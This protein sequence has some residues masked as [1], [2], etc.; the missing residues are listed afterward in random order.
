VDECKPLGDGSSDEGE[1]EGDSP[2]DGY[3]GRGV[4]SFTHQPNVSAF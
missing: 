1:V 4:H 3:D 2:D